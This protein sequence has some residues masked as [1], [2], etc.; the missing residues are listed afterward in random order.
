MSVTVVM[1]GH[2]RIL[3]FG[4]ARS[5]VAVSA[6]L[7]VVAATSASAEAARTPTC[8]KKSG[9]TVVATKQARVFKKGGRVYACLYRL[10]RH[11]AGRR[12]LLGDGSVRNVR[13]AGRFVGY[14]RVVDTGPKVTV[15]EL[16][17]GRLVHNARPTS[18]SPAPPVVT[19]LV[20][21]RNG[22]VAWIAG[23]TPLDIPMAPPGTVVPRPT[24][25]VQK[26]DRD[27]SAVLDQGRDIAPGSL[28]L[29]RSTVSWSKG[30]RTY[31]AQLN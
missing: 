10:A 25:Q 12:F 27:S 9:T 31:S 5:L 22:S 15:K 24:Y 21:K 29:R 8:T 26:A 2:G 20:L 16:R 6:A 1:V 19:D 4:S 17:R 13:L 11:R 3:S 23:S 18:L 30:G 14:S 7:A 28:A